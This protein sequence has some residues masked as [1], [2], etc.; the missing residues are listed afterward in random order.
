[1]LQLSQVYV[2][3]LSREQLPLV[4]V[5]LPVTGLDRIPLR[6]PHKRDLVYVALVPSHEHHLH[7]HSAPLAG[8]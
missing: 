7:R 4:G 5:Q 8:E 6:L 2:D 1:M 3:H